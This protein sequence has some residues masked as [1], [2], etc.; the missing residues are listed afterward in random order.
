[1]DDFLQF[2]NTASAES[3]TKI[4]GI[5][6]NLAESLIAAR[7]FN[8][9]DDCLRV[10]GMGK[11]L[12]ARAQSAFENLEPEPKELAMLPSEEKALI[13]NE[14]SQPEPE[15]AQDNKP[16]FGSRVRQILLNVLRALLRLILLV[17]LIGGISAIIYY[18]VPYLRKSFITPVEQNAARVSDLENEVSTL[19]TRLTEINQQL[20]TTNNRIDMIEQSVEADSASLE[21][22][23]AMQTTLETQLKENDDKTLLALKHEIM[24][25]R[26]LDML[27]RARLYL[28][29]SNFGLAKTDVQSAR[30]LLVELQ[31]KSTDMVP[32]QTITSLDLALGNLPDFPVVASGDLEIA[33]QILMTGKVPVTATPEPTSTST[34]ISE[35]TLEP[36]ATP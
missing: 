17:L 24:L 31:A 33:W 5:S 22:L 20:T 21:K 13:P 12:L 34:H 19:Q 1:M 36:T 4:P 11:N 30:D 28:A 10:R 7:P 35:P 18:G 3:L 6:Q 29:Q 16:S 9:I 25:T 27:A 26:A 14:K 23:A 2:L 15:P 32:A 8:S